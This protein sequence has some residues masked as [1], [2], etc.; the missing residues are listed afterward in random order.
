MVPEDLPT[1]THALLAGLKSVAGSIANSQQQQGALAA[2]LCEELIES[3]DRNVTALETLEGG[4]S[5]S[6]DS[7][8]YLLKYFISATSMAFASASASATTLSENLRISS[9]YYQAI[10]S[11]GK[12]LQARLSNLSD[13]FMQQA[14]PCQFCGGEMVFSKPLWNPLLIELHCLSCKAG[15][16]WRMAVEKNSVQVQRT[17]FNGSLESTCTQQ[18]HQITVTLDSVESADSFV[19]LVSSDQRVAGGINIRLL[20]KPLRVEVVARLRQFYSNGITKDVGEHNG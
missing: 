4:L 11:H 18:S 9:D 6:L 5:N 13:L 8:G 2:K 7:E 10:E 20:A 17:P 15:S 1:L 14:A 12:G 16:H 19:F 3:D